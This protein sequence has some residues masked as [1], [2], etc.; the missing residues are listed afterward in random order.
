MT[1]IR[2]IGFVACVCVGIG[3]PGESFAQSSAS[4]IRGRNAGIARH[5]AASNPRSEGDQADAEGWPL[6]RT[7]RGQAAFND[8]MATLKATDVGPAPK[9]QA[10]A[11]CP[12]LRCNLKLPEAKAD[13]WLPSGRLWVSPSEYV[14]FVQS[15]RLPE[16]RSYRRRTVM[17]QRYFVFHEF[18]NSSRNTDL[19]DTISSH[20][21]GVFVPFYLGKEATDAKGRRF[22]TVVQVAPYDVQSIHATNW[23][24]AGPGVEVA[25][26][27]NEDLEPLQ[28]K[29]GI[30]LATMVK[31]AVPR[32]QMVNHRGAEGKAM[33][34]AY[35]Q[36][37]AA[38]R[39]S[40]TAPAVALPFVA[41]HPN[42]LVTAAAGRIE[43]LVKREA[44]RPIAVADRGFM[45]RRSGGRGGWRSAALVQP[46]SAQAAEPVAEPVL[47]EPPRLVGRPV[48][49]GVPR[50]IGPIRPVQR[51]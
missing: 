22:V 18:H 36:L 31:A 26:N 30:L 12:Q 20:A 40:A 4:E 45:G 17:A 35:E 49:G 44:S 46:A 33:L 8:A 11:S 21:G 23:G 47:I 27:T 28:A 43:D 15:P 16:G 25:K 9:P 7:E 37:L 51:P 6:Y 48:N 29:A 10:F 41:V 14:L 39:S 1:A 5:G 42:K 38:L 19:F 2:R 3:Q 32:L 13:G 50:L 34:D 24:S